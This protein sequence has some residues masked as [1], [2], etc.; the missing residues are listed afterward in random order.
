MKRRKRPKMYEATYRGKKVRVTI[1]KRRDSVAY[2]GDAADVLRDVLKDSLSPLAVAA[3]AS[4]LQT[5]HTND[6]ETNRQVSWFAEQLR[7]L[8]GGDEQQ[9]RLAEELGL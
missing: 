7:N 2:S 3:I 9:S 4:C 8:L 6:P 1:P 5:S